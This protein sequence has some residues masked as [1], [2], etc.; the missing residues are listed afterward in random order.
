MDVSVGRSNRADSPHDPRNSGPVEVQRCV[1]RGE[2][3][4]LRNGVEGFGTGFCGC[5]GRHPRH[6]VPS[7]RFDSPGRR[8]D[9]DG[10]EE[11]TQDESGPRA[12]ELV[13]HV[14]ALAKLLRYANGDGLL[15]F[16]VVQSVSQATSP[17]SRR[18]E[19][20]LRPTSRRESDGVPMKN[21]LSVSVRA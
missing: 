16:R 17:E 3:P 9:T 21:A 4:A 13:G 6:R 1:R 8:I 2:R 19:L 7:A 15:R 18:R 10:R 5:R 20:S 14:V 12:V 11:D